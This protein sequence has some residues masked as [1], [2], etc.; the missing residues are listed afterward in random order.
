MSVYVTII[1]S[2]VIATAGLGSEDIKVNS[3]ESAVVKHTMA[4]E[5]ERSTAPV[6]QALNH[7]VY[8]R[9]AII[10]SYKIASSDFDY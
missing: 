5:T 3:Y 6:W 10:V 1:I 7:A 4:R 9:V 8:L 2:Y